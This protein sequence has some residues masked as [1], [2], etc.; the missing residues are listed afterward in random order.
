MPFTVSSVVSLL[1]SDSIARVTLDS[2]AQGVGNLDL[3]SEVSVSVAVGQEEAVPLGSLSTVNV[4][5]LRTDYPVTVK[6]NGG[7]TGFELQEDGLALL[8]GVSVTEIDLDNTSGDHKATVIARLFG[9]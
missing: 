7:V 6:L 9:V 4:L 8:L 5:W 1:K 3:S 2:A